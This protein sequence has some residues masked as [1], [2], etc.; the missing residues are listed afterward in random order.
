MSTANEQ[1]SKALSEWAELEHSGNTTA[2]APRLTAD[3]LGVGPLGFTLTK[4]EWLARHA[5]G[6]LKYQSFQL[7]EVATRVYGDTAV[8][9]ARQSVHGAYRGTPIPTDVR[10]TLVLVKPATD[11]QLAG[12]HMSFIAGTPGAP[13]LPGRG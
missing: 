10:A 4:E 6:D 12:I 13:P 11:W 2:L 7:A 9:T 8:T 3:F 5:T 1:I